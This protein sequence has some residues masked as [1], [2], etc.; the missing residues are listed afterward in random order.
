M[1]LVN[2]RRREH[3]SA[4]VNS[5]QKA[6]RALFCSLRVYNSIKESPATVLIVALK[7]FN[8]VRNDIE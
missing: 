3:E 6:G 8:V 2:G 5:N 4:L 7:A 1:C